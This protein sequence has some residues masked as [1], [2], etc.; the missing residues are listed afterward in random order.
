MISVL[1][2]VMHPLVFIVHVYQFIV[3][4]SFV[5][6]HCKHEVKNPLIKLNLKEYSKFI[7]VGQDISCDFELDEI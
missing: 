2:A 4:I 7:I 5:Y 1:L 6:L 3:L